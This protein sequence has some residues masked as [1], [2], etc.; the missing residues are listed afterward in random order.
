M[1]LSYNLPKGNG[2]FAL[3]T[4]GHNSLEFVGGNARNDFCKTKGLEVDEIAQDLR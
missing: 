4:I 2:F 3:D 1:Y